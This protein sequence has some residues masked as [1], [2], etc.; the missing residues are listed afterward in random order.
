MRFYCIMTPRQL[1]EN[2]LN[3]WFES[4]LSKNPFLKIDRRAAMTL[5]YSLSLL[6]YLIS[7]IPFSIPS[8][9]VRFIYHD[10]LNFEKDPMVFVCG[11]KWRYY[12]NCS[13]FDDVTRIITKRFYVSVGFSCF[14][15]SKILAKIITVCFYVIH[16]CCK[17]GDR[18]WNGKFGVQ[19][20]PVRSDIINVFTCLLFRPGSWLRCLFIADS[21]Q[22]ILWHDVAICRHRN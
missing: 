21:C 6:V 14:M 15:Y 22:R 3:F 11:S 4:E 2:K 10:W 9:S 1:A 5:W 12:C 16:Y 13:S 18:L 20:C 17:Q 8:R 7:W 19:T